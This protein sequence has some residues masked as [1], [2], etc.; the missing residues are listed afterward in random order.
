M[1]RPG[2]GNGIRLAAG[3]TPPWLDGAG[4]CPP[5]KLAQPTSVAA[6]P[7][8][9]SR[10]PDLDKLK[11]RSKELL[12]GFAPAHAA[13]GIPALFMAVFFATAR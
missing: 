12:A 1:P 10:A 9:P 8:A 6:R 7:P 2:Q 3:H 5:Y 4:R 11:R 13:L